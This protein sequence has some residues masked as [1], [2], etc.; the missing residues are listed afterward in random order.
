MTPSVPLR[1]TAV[2]VP[3]PPAHRP[4]AIGL[5][6][7][8]AAGALSLSSFS[9]FPLKSSPEVLADEVINRVLQ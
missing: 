8:M 1:D 4:D 7:G 6:R 5:P 9:S 2:E 3:L